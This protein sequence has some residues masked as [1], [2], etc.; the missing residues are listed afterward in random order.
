MPSN[1]IHPEDELTD[2]QKAILRERLKTVEEDARHA[3]DARQAIKEMRLN[4][5]KKTVPR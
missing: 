4:L 5:R 3:V 2:K 1:N